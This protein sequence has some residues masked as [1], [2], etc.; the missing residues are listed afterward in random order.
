MAEQKR[1]KLNNIDVAQPTKFDYNFATT[2]T[3]DSGRPQG[4]KAKLTPLF[5]VESFDVE[6]KNLTPQEATIILNIIIP[7]PTTPFFDMYY[8]SP[9][10]GEW[11]TKKFY[12]GDGSLVLR[13]LKQGNE[14]IDY[15]AAS[16]VGRDKI[17]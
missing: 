10:A 1:I 7:K 14:G 13:S 16:F 17:C 11:H 6:F 3:E 12:V 4:G 8:Y 2:F 15:I 5:T 9:Y